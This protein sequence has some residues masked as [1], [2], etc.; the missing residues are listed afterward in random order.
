MTHSSP[1]CS[2]RVRR[3][4]TVEP[5]ASSG[6]RRRRVALA[7]LAR[8]PA[9]Q[10]RDAHAEA[11]LVE[12]ARHDVMRFLL[13][14]DDLRDRRAAAPAPFLGPG[15]AGEAGGFFLRLPRLGA[16]DGAGRALAGAIALG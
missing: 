12:A 11:D 15:D 1:W 7:L 6:E 13:M 5:A 14:V 8:A 16:L 4:A 2:A 3:P 9:A 10:R